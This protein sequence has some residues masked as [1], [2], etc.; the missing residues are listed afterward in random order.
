MQLIALG[1][2]A[3]LA[4]MLLVAGGAKLADLD[5]FAGTARLFLP[6][7]LPHRTQRWAALGVALAELAT[8]GVS[9]SAPAL[10]PVNLVVLGLGCAFVAVSAAGYVFYRGRACRCFGG[11]SR[12]TFDRPA[13]LRAAAVVAVAVLALGHVPAAATRVGAVSEV[14]L[15]LAAALVAAAAFTA[16]RALAVSRDAQP[17]LAPR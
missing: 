1:A 13:I 7:R 16:A 11:L 17:R 15:G 5:S 8:G 4:V 10:R 3:A 9:L 2:K 14:L 6:R 12:K